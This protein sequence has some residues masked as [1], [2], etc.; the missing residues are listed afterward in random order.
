MT[1]TQKLKDIMELLRKETASANEAYN[2]DREYDSLGG[3]SVNCAEACL[4]LD[5]ILEEAEKIFKTPFH[6]IS[7]LC[8]LSRS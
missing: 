5:P 4:T 7:G 1:D 2:E 3:C 6:D 8:G